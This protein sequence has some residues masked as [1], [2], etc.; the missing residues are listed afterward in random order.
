MK[1]MALNTPHETETRRQSIALFNL[2]WNKPT[3]QLKIFTAL[4]MSAND[5]ESTMSTDLGIV[6]KCK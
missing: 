2:T 1:N 6:N 3:G 4:P 5:R